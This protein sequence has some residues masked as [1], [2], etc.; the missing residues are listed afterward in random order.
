M[1]N[2]CLLKKKHKDV[3]CNAIPNP[4]LQKHWGLQ[5]L[6][7]GYQKPGC[8]HHICSNPNPRASQGATVINNC[9]MITE[10]HKLGITALSQTSTDA[11]E[12]L[13]WR[14][15]GR[16]QSRGWTWWR[17]LKGPDKSGFNQCLLKKT[18]HPIYAWFYLGTKIPTSGTKWEIIISGKTCH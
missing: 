17:G 18:M 5:T 12:C 11:N 14:A 9:R 7:V 1:P 10:Y 3:K 8:Q 15:Q 13:K 16:M 2:A 6:T 4:A